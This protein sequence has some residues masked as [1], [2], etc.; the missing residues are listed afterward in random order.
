M[1]IDRNSL[2]VIHNSEASRFEIHIDGQ[3][4]VLDYRLRAGI[5][6]FTHTGVPKELEGNGIGSL[7]VCAGLDY[8]REKGYKVIPLCPFVDVYIQR[9]SEYEEIRVMA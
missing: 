3:M 4:P 1:K 8:A 5:I 6:T 9:H 7:I 2:K